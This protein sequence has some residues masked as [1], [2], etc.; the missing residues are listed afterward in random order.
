[1]PTRGDYVLGTQDDEIARL[2]LQHQVWRPRM[3]DA[4]RRAG[5]TRGSR[6]LDVGA[7]PGYATLD[8][9]ETVGPD[10]DIV[11]LERSPRFA[12]ELRSRVAQRGLTNVRVSEVDLMRD[13][14][15]ARG[16][17]AAWCRWVACFVS[18]PRA[19]IQSIGQALR[20]GGAAVFHE[21]A[22]YASWRLLPRCRSFESFVGEV[23][24]NWRFNGGEPDIAL[25]LPTLLAD[26]G[27]RVRHV[28]PL[29]FAVGPQDFVWQWPAGFLKSHLP[30]L[31]EMGR[32]DLPW[33]VTVLEEFEAAEGDPRTL[34]LT[35]VVLE[36]IA[37]KVKTEN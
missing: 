24:A 10:G 6:V 21:Y 16:F 7:G 1:M 18:S 13:P 23:M 19:L 36:V 8:L 34:M 31:V 28:A 9:A 27:F 12:A 33:T 22:D 3:L 32:A 2:G 35:P 29:V 14:I 15:D 26:A 5:I 11:A 17:D 30:R 20:P 4:W 25:A 37:E